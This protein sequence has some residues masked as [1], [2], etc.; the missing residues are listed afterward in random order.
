MATVFKKEEWGKDEVLGKIWDIIR[1]KHKMAN[2]TRKNLMKNRHIKDFCEITVHF[3][4]MGNEL[5]ISYETS[6][7]LRTKNDV[8]IRID[9]VT[10]YDDFMEYEAVRNRGLHSGKPS[11]IPNIN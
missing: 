2:H 6:T 3:I 7:W 5:Y 11:D 9:S 8:A 1:S 4:N 10:V